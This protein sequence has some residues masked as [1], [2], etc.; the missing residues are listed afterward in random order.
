[1]ANSNY[2]N[3]TPSEKTVSVAFDEEPK[4]TLETETVPV[5]EAK[6]ESEPVAEV[7]EEPKP[8]KAVSVS[9]STFK[10]N[11]C[12]TYTR[13]VNV[14]T[15]PELKA[16]VIGVRSVG[17]SVVPEK[18]HEN[19]GYIWAEYHSSPKHVRFV[20]LGTSDGTETF[21]K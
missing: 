2:K 17:E 19:D 13:S 20:A 21:V 5:V 4:L 18:L 3:F 14:H 15:E 1:M 8:E 16:L 6:S 9:A 10:P 7:V 11:K 12:Y